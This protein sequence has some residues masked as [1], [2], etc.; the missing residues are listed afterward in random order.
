[1]QVDPIQEILRT[2]SLTALTTL[3]LRDY[4][5]DME[6]GVMP[7]EQGVDQRIRF[8]VDLHLEGASAPPEDEID[9]VLDYDFIRAQVDKAANGPRFNLLESLVS[10]LL[11]SFTRP[12]EVLAACVTATKL[13]IYEGGTEV[14]CRMIRLRE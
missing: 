4:I 1:M 9:Q 11:D 5:V 8:E 14:G 12:P 13:D 7:E 6:L 2:R 3:Q 10:D